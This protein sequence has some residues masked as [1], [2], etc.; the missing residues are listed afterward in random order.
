MSCLPAPGIGKPAPQPQSQDVCGACGAKN[1]SGMGGGTAEV[2]SAMGLEGCEESSSSPPLPW[3]PDGSRQPQDFAALSQRGT[4]PSAR[5]DPSRQASQ[6]L[7][8]KGAAHS[9]PTHAHYNPP[10]ARKGHRS[11]AALVSAGGGS[12]DPQLPVIP[13]L[14]PKMGR[15]QDFRQPPPALLPVAQLPSFSSL[16]PS[17]SC[18]GSWSRPLPHPVALCGRG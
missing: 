15:S 13:V 17:E 9:K 5:Y 1:C 7:T 3:A 8:F 14:G 10:P 6:L 18:R 12:E 2:E 16:A 4:T 11:H